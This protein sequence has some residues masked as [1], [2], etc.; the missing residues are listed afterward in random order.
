MHHRFRE[1]LIGIVLL[2]ALIALGTVIS[3]GAKR[4][5][6]GFGPEWDCSAGYRGAVDC[7]KFNLSQ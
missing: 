5:N 1:N 6:Y 2:V 3:I 4:A 7:A